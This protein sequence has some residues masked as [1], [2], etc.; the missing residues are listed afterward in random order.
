[1]NTRLFEQSDQPEL[2]SFCKKRILRAPGGA[3]MDCAGG[4]DFKERGII[5]LSVLESGGITKGEMAHA[6]ALW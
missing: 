3:V 5:T 2:N 4:G 6:S 1:M